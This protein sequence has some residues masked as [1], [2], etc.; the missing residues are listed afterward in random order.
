[1]N[2]PGVKGQRGWHQIS[3][4]LEMGSIELGVP[5]GL[6]IGLMRRM[7][8][9]AARSYVNSAIPQLCRVA[10]CSDVYLG[11]GFVCFVKIPFVPER[12]RTRSRAVTVQKYNKNI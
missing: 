8:A 1:M 2:K 12:N 7:K 10:C 3:G 5:I 4:H 6:K 9:F 11:F